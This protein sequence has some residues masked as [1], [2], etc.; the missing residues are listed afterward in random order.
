MLTDIQAQAA[1]VVA[2]PLTL[3]FENQSWALGP[4]QL[5]AALAYRLDGG[6]LVVALDPKALQPFLDGVATAVEQPGVSAKIDVDA[7]GHFVVVPD[8]PGLVLDRAATLAAIDAALTDG[9]HEA[10]AVRVQRAAPIVAADLEPVR[11]QAEKIAS[12]PLTVN[13]AEY[14]RVFVR[15]DIQPLLVFKAQP[16]QAQ[17]VTIALDPAGVRHLSEVIAR[18]LNQQVQDAQ[19]RWADGAVRAVVP[20]KDGRDVQLAGTDA[21]LTQAIL[22]ATGAATPAVAVTPPKVPSSDAA[23][24]A[25]P[26]NR[27]GY[28]K[29]YYGQS[30]PTRKHNV[31]L[32]VSRLDGTLIAPGA[33]FSFNQAVG[34]QT[35]ANGYQEAYGIAMTG[36]GQVTTVSSI[37]GGICQVATTLFQ[38]VFAAGFPIQERNWHLYWIEGYGAPPS[39]MQGLDATVDDQAG[40]DFKFVNSTPNWLAIEAVAD[41]EYVRIAI[42]GQDPG[43]T[44]QI[45]A[46]VITNVKPHDPK[47]VYEKTHDLPPG[48]QLMIEHGVDGF[49]AAIH[50][51]VVD[52]DGKVVIWNSPTGPVPMDTTFTSHYVPAQDRYQVGVPKDQ[53]A[54]DGN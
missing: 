52:K 26:H 32:A 7:E 37:A 20:S 9:R 40:L 21:A 36:T 50:R 46:P 31:E 45:D 44:V 33:T 6:R 34:A 54:D 43:W 35:V 48:Q 17:K 51:T 19:F 4:D 47:P 49:D 27:L 10:T 22:G 39:G 30:I 2:Q 24:M 8:K 29:T 14:N 18:D 38:G 53:P 15:S 25:I 11:A 5:R 3:R 1:A 28:G 16:G 41:G 23:K 12:T 13:F 42:Y